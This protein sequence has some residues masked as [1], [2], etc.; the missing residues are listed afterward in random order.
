MFRS[1][2]ES[3][4]SYYQADIAGIVEHGIWRGRGSPGLKPHFHNESQIVM[5]LSGS[6]AFLIDG[7]AMTVATGQAA[8]IPAGMLHTPL[9]TTEGETI[10][11][12]TYVPE[13]D[14]PQSLEIFDIQHHWS[15]AGWISRDGF[16][17]VWHEISS[18]TALHPTVKADRNKLRSTL[19]NSFG[20]R[21]LIA[22]LRMAHRLLGV[23]R[24]RLG[25]GL[26]GAAGRVVDGPAAD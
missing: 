20:R 13:D 14:S 22:V 16:L 23:S 25:L 3:I 12:N 6:R 26:L 10:C 2:S 7:T 5:V 24:K 9:A 21:R 1:A 19:T 15:S 4:W 17:S 8:R 11:L 18:S